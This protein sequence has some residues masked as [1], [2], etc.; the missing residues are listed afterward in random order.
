MSNP[1]PIPID[2]SLT[3]DE[4]YQ[5]RLAMTMGQA[6]PSSVSETSHPAVAIPL[7]GDEA[8]LRRL[9][10]SQGQNT[11]PAP[12]PQFTAALSTVPANP[13]V[14]SVVS[15]P[16]PIV[17]APVATSPE[18]EERLKTSREAAAAVAARL[19][20]LAAAAPADPETPQEPPSADEK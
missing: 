1:P 17:Q 15:P 6:V 3:G 7:T 4:A 9:A 5:R 11:S 20:K 13:F 12:T 18:F 10:M 16:V 19:A 2:T 14:S 8:Y